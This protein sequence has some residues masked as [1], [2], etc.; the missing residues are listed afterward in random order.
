MTNS[1]QL[2]KWLN[3]SPSYY[4]VVI[5]L[6]SNYL[7][8]NDL[9]NK[10]FKHISED[11]IGVDFKTTIVMEDYPACEKAVGKCIENH[12]AIERVYVRKPDE[13][14]GSF[15]T[16]WDFS[17]MESLEGTPGILCVGH[18]VTD[19]NLLYQKN[20][21]N[22]QKLNAILDSTTDS[23]I[24]ID[25]NYKITSF[26]EVARKDIE[27]HFKRNVNIGDDI[28]EFLFESTKHTFYT[29]FN[30]AIN[31]EKVTLEREMDFNKGYTIWFEISYIP[32]YNQKNEVVGV[33]FNSTN[34][35]Q[36][37]KAELKLIEKTAHLEKIAWNHAH[38]IR[39]PLANILGLIELLAE[40]QDKEKYN[41]LLLLLSQ[42]SRELD[43]ALK[44]NL[45]KSQD[46]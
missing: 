46:N 18:D 43:S 20:E 29:N 38:E 1:Y 15:W 26:N 23:N 3:N 45:N 36:R 7:F 8:T 4:I 44:E 39:K 32:L 12:D 41:H 24:L 11:F 35:D 28:Q 13:N 42:S 34:I 10:K 22:E 31:G 9:F 33:S 19:L 21:V 17:Y 16:S 5:G 14:N 25:K 2:P 6:D 40:E 30:K 27:A 37:K